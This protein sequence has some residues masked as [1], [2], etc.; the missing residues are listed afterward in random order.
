MDLDDLPVVVKEKVYIRGRRGGTDTVYEYTPSSDVWDTLPPPTVNGFT[1][2]TLNEQLVLV[3]GKDKS[4]GKASNKIAVWD[5]GKHQWIYPYPSM[6]TGQSNPAAVGYREQLIVSGGRNSE[7]N[8]IP[9]VI[10]L[11]MTSNKWLTAES[12]PDTDYYKSVMIE[13]TLYLV[14][15]NRNV[16]QANI[17]TLISRASST[18]P[19]VSP[20]VWESLPNAPFYFSFPVA[21]NK[22]LMTVGGNNTCNTLDPNSTCTSSIQLYN[23]TNN[24]WTNVGNLPISVYN[25]PCTVISGELLVLGGWKGLTNFIRSVYVSKLTM[26]Y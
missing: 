1:M 10:I 9:D 8:R 24:E 18:T 17:P 15:D 14:G 25:C 26:Q 13:D 2:A 11:D 4:T 5:S 19:S 16:L 3:G 21:G 20:N 7:G 12:L 23:P 6:T 22:V